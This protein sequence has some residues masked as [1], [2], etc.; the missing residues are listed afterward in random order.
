MDAK[1][2]ATRIKRSKLSKKDELFLS[3]FGKEREDVLREIVFSLKPKSYV[4]AS[5]GLG[6]SI[7][8]AIIQLAGVYAW[9]NVD[10]RFLRGLACMHPERIKVAFTLGLDEVIIL[11][12]K[13]ASKRRIRDEVLV[14]DP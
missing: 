10:K 14:H 3:F 11:P 4:M 1:K 12:Q 13:R 2:E 8:E 5:R 9:I 6:N 7:E